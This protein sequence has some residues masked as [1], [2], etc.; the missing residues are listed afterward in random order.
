MAVEVSDGLLARA[1]EIARELVR[2]ATENG[3]TVSTAESC[4]AGMVASLIADVPG[5]SAVLRGGAVTYCDEVKHRVLGVATV[6]LERYT[7]VSRQTAFEMAAGSR[8]LFGS[9]A[10]V[11]L[12]GYAGPGGGTVEDSAGTVYI[13]IDDEAGARVE[14]CSFTGG[15]NEVRLRAAVRALELL[16]DSCGVRAGSER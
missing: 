12:T 16:V 8:R 5:A 11:S 6:T 15:R 3:L 14:R 10:A 2:V 1:D 7:A 13:G 9:D 4:T